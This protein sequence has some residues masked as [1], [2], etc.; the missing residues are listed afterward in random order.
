[1]LKICVY[2][3]CKNEIKF[4]DKWLDNVSE[5]DYIVVLDTGSTDGTYEKLKADKRVTVVKQKE[6]K[7]WRFDVA[8]N[9]SM[10]LIPKDTDICVCTDFDELFTPGW[11]RAVRDNWKK[12]TNRMF[13]TYAWGQTPD[14]FW[15]DI[16]RGDKIHGP[17]GFKWIYPI[18]E[19]LYSDD[20]Q[21]VVDFGQTLYLYHHQDTSK[22]R[23]YYLDL[24]KLGAEEN[25][26][27][28][29]IRVL[30]AREFIIEG[31]VT[32]ENIKKAIEEYVEVLKL[33][34]IEEECYNLEKLHALIQLALIF[35]V[36]DHEYEKALKCCLKF[37]EY[38]QT[39]R[40]PYLVMAGIFNAE[41]L[42]VLAEACLNAAKEYTY[43]HYTWIER[44]NTFLDWMPSI[45]Y[46]TKYHLGKFDEALDAVGRALE[47]CPDSLEY[48]KNQNII[49]RACLDAK[50]KKE[51][52]EAE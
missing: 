45:E 16:F 31:N 8:R 37:L 20:P 13:Y 48:L 5:A 35:F 1:M 3:I 36:Y 11:A 32:P 14:G 52:K 21:N 2:A 17:K 34:N 23:K 46:D 28:P 15:H 4:V 7:P 39:Y 9:E 12:D 47:F 6:I 50:N 33:P 41:G 10:K 29:H 27:D 19:I 26:N 40:D 44:Q 43:Q 42:Y 22:P 51:E 30:Y 24:L 38:D 18:H 25:P 49:L